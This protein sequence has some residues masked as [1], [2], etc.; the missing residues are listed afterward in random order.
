MEH[1]RFYPLKNSRN[2]KFSLRMPPWR[3]NMTLRSRCLRVVGSP[4]SG[5]LRADR[6]RVQITFG[7]RG[8]G[9]QETFGLIGCRRTGTLSGET[10]QRGSGDFQAERFLGLGRLWANHSG[11]RQECSSEHG[12]GPRVRAPDALS[13]CRTALPTKTRRNIGPKRRCHTGSLTSSSI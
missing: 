7:W 3:W 12:D 2:G 4:G 1:I 8:P 11:R 9:N 10:A 13:R 6:F 5:N